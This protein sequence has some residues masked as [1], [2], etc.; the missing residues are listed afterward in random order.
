MG[1]ERIEV[2]YQYMLYTSKNE[3]NKFKTGFDL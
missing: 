3:K 1:G 2:Y